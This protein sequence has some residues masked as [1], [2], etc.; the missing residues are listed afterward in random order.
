MFKKSVSLRRKS[1]FKYF[2]TDHIS[3]Y[4]WSYLLFGIIAVLG[5][6]IGFVVG[7]NRADNFALKDLP[8]GVL[9][10]FLNNKA[11][12]ASVFFSR[13]FGFLGLCLLI[14]CVNAK[15]FLCW[16]SFFIFLYRSFLLGINSAILISLYKFGGV[17]NVV[18]IYFPVHL[19]ALFLLLSLCVV[20]FVCCLRQK[21]TGYSVFSGYFFR[22]HKMLMFLVICVA[23]VCFLVESI[24]LPHIT[25]AL[26]IGVS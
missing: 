19:G 16:I 23:F 15:G 10:H 20:C 12:A 3:Q 7:F 24:V 1:F 18:L 22:E 17:V 14:L 13:F 5:L 4:K 8:D 9:V 25:S 26:F 21:N 11:S 6:I 2:V